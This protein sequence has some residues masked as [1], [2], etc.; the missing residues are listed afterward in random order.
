MFRIISKCWLC[1]RRCSSH[2]SFFWAYTTPQ[3]HS[4]ITTRPPVPLDFSRLTI[5]C[6]RLRLHSPT[7]PLSYAAT[8]L[9]L[10]SST[11]SLA[12][13]VT[14]LTILASHSTQLRSIAARKPSDNTP[15]PIARGVAYHAFP[16]LKQWVHSSSLYSTTMYLM[17][18]SLLCY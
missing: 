5:L 15:G 12:Y 1:A 13:A 17:L 3:W 6:T 18:L 4:P 7:N 14:F 9:R 11:S 8:C 2:S 16:V 10:H